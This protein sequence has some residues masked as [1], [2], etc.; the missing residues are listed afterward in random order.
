[1]SVLRSLYRGDVNIDFRPWWRRSVIISGAVVV[2]ALLLLLIRGLNLSIDFEGGGV[3]EVPVPDSVDVA[4]ARATLP[5]MEDARVQRVEDPDRGTFIRVQ[6]GTVDIDRSP[7]IVAALAELGQV[8]G[9]EVSVSTV[10]PTW[11]SQITGKALRALILFF[12]AVAVYL[13]WTLEWRM[14]I[15]ALAAVIHDLTITAGVYSLFAFEVSPATIIAL[16]TI[17]GYSIYDTVVVYDKVLENQDSPVGDGVTPTELINRSM[18]Q[19][20]MRS[21]NTTITTVLPVAS[22]LIIGGVL[23]GGATLRDFALALFI[24]LIL[25][26]YSSIFLAAPLLAWLKEREPVTDD[27]RRRQQRAAEAFGGEIG[28]V[29]SGVAQVGPV[30]R[31]RKKKRRR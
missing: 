4:E 12:L 16:L 21:I 27:A 24:G 15:G 26:T 20:L 14:A 22:M 9:D 6:S 11:G 25:G 31:G 17:L 29:A 13:A 3:W 1:M 5:G 18:N 19:V 28:E 10:G 2:I 8:S 30:A 23:L 7:E